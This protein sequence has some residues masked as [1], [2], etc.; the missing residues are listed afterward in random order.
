MSQPGSGRPAASGRP[1]YGPEV[2]GNVL[3]VRRWESWSELLEWLRA[4]GVGDAGLGPGELRALR[5][6]AERAAARGAPLPTDA[7]R[8]WRELRG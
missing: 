8:M 4:E 6:D 7:D 1:D 2:V 3:A 5:Q